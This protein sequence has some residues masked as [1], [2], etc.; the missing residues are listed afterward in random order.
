LGVDVENDSA[1]RGTGKRG[2]KAVVLEMVEAIG[3][4]TGGGHD[5]SGGT[6][7]VDDTILEHQQGKTDLV[8][9]RDTDNISVDGRVDQYVGQIPCRELLGAGKLVV[10]AATQ[11]D[12]DM[13][14]DDVILTTGEWLTSHM[15]VG[16][17]VQDGTIGA[18]RSQGRVDDGVKCMEERRKLAVKRVDHIDAVEE[19]AF[20]QGQMGL[21]PMAGAG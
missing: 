14:G 6:D 13:A 8:E 19:G 20:N 9:L 16:A 10:G 3:A 15:N 21:G 11:T 1:Q 12:R 2:P 18:E 5:G 7:D 4:E 17:G